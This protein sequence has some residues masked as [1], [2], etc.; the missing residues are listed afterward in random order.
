MD[1]H[2]NNW[3]D[4]VEG[5]EEG[6]SNKNIEKERV[7]QGYKPEEKKEQMAKKVLFG[8]KESPKETKAFNYLS[9]KKGMGKN[10]Y[11]GK[12]GEY[13]KTKQGNFMKVHPLDR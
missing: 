7:R 8:K 3:L 4:K 10:V 1:K 11:T 6:S 5:R 2:L 9:N 13:S 12:K